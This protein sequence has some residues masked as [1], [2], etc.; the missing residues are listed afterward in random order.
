MQ[1]RRV[2][3]VVVIAMVAATLS[4]GFPAS[5]EPEAL[6]ESEAKAAQ[7]VIAELE[8]A[9]DGPL[10]LADLSLDDLGP[11]PWTSFVPNRDPAA[12]EVWLMLLDRF[13]ELKGEPSGI[14]QPSVLVTVSEAEPASR[15]GIND[16]PE[17]GQ[18]VSGFGTGYTDNDFARIRGF[19]YEPAPPPDCA[20]VEDDGAISSS[21]PTNGQGPA[22]IHI[23]TGVLGDGP[24]AETTGDFDFYTFHEAAE[25]SLLIVD[26]LPNR[27]D[28]E[29]P[30]TSIAIFDSDGNLLGSR[31]DKRGIYLD[32][33]EVT[34]PADGDYYAVVGGLQSALSDPFD[35]A[36]GSGPT[37]TGA[38]EVAIVNFNVGPTCESFE[39]DGSIDL[40]NDA[41]EAVA[42]EGIA[43]CFAF[44]GD[45]PFGETSGDF[46][47]YF[48]GELGAGL[49]AIV[50]IIAFSGDPLT[51]ATAAL[52]NSAGELIGSTVDDGTDE[53][54][55]ETELPADDLYFALVGS[56]LPAD[57]FDSSSGSGPVGSGE[58]GVAVG[59][60]FD[61][62]GPEYSRWR[63][64]GDQLTAPDSGEPE[65]PEFD[66]DFY[67]IEL[68][69][70]DVLSAGFDPELGLELYDPEGE[71]LMGSWGFP[72]SIAYPLA[73]P[74]RHLGDTGI[75]HVAKTSGIYALAVTEGFGPYDGE[76][77]VSRPGLE[78]ASGSDAQIIYLDF[79]GAIVDPSIFDPFIPSSSVELSPLEDFLAG[80]GLGGADENRVINA[81]IETVEAEL[82]DHLRTRGTYGDRDSSGE[83][84]ELD[85]EITN[86]RD[87]PEMWGKPNVSRVIVGGTIDELGLE[88]IGIAQ[89]IDPGNLDPTETAV[90]LLDLL[91]AEA[92]EDLPTLNN[93]DW[94]DPYTKSDV[95]G[96][97][98]GVIVAHEI[99]H[100]IGNWHTET[101]NESFQIMD[102]GGDLAGTLGSGPDLIFGNDD[103]I[104]VHFG[105]DEFNTFEGFTGTEDTE[106]RSGFALQTGPVRYSGPATGTSVDDLAEHVNFTQPDA[107][108]LRLYLAF[109]N[110][111]PDVKG[112][113]YWVR[114]R[115]EGS[116]LANIS[117]YFTLSREFSLNYAGTSN[118]EFLDR[119]YENVLGRNYDQ[120]GFDYW[121]AL[122]TSGSLDRAGVVMWISL[123]DEFVNANLYGGY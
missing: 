74:L 34:A 62:P 32:A 44:L 49:N 52:Y 98:I 95:V 89:S 53:T 35:P 106:A 19:L 27:E 66:T 114:I 90:V 111:Q 71:L 16:T 15:L 123:N 117:G 113:N 40:S 29:Q 22:E 20:S 107:Q 87:H 14:N 5:A 67:L 7:Q 37:T 73:S 56:G 69:A 110:R 43:F 38:Y 54:F 50:D 11:P 94:V 28:F 10:T 57:P 92:G 93:F 64:L 83:A 72:G 59:V 51:G 121:L 102:A 12:I 116:T 85:V 79:D 48:L 108:V 3:F 55:L 41:S 120:G 77:R 4:S 1:I 119:V 13:P 100:Y 6:H 61:G 118:P 25:G 91:S 103:D 63:N 78:S 42:F 46:D 9:G 70:G 58:Y 105:S 18:A 81:V 97:G 36:S 8:A 68:E 26:V 65:L 24:R 17:T 104:E 30:E 23:C 45:G 80:W 75:D 88:T 122:L 112:A 109:F 60:S 99:G 96:H 21:S 86:S 101:F 82:H 76:L 2:G 84:F 31:D 39:D 115:H 33:L 47:F